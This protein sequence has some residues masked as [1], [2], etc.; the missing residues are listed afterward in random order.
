MITLIYIDEMFASA[1]QKK[2]I[3]QIYGSFSFDKWIPIFA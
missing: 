2:M 3:K 1:D